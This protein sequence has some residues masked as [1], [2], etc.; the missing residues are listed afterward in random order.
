MPIFGRFEVEPLPQL[1][2]FTQKSFTIQFV[3]EKSMPCELFFCDI[4]FAVC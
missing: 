2:C 3:N 1:D 4:L